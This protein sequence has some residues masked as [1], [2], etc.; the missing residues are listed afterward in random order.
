MN[1]AQFRF[2]AELNEFL[3]LE[4]RQ[5]L[6]SQPTFDGT[7]SVKHLIEA[8]GIPHTEVELIIANGE[9]IDFSYQVQS[10]DLISV[11]PVFRSPMITPPT[12]LRPPV[13]KPA[14][15][16][17]DNHLGKLARYLRLL[18]FDSLYFH[19]QLNDE[20]LAQMA[21]DDNRI[22]L[23]RDR[24]LLMRSLVVYGYCIRSKDSRKQTTAVLDRFQLHSQIRPWRRCLRC[25]GNLTPIN[26]E[27]II[28]RLEPKTK[29]YY[30][31]FQICVACNQIYWRG[32]HYTKLQQFV[33]EIVK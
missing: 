13:P 33:N 15:F 5:K 9:A 19:D 8:I 22:L 11:Y 6:F 20:K 10:G 31:E 4:K 28:D 12:L 32:S 29:R 24:G 1:Q 17:L 26:K 16:I 25:N 27:Q 14:H 23:S 21:Y 7:Q 2:Y 3:P 18:G 30:D